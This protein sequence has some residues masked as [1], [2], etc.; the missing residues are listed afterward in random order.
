MCIGGDGTPHEVLNGIMDRPNGA[1]ILRR[2]HLCLVPAGT[3]NGLTT[4]IGISSP[5]DSFM[6]LVHGNSRQA[7]AM[8]IEQETNPQFQ[9]VYSLLQVSFG[10]MSDVDF[11]SE[12]IRWMGD[13]RFETL[14]RIT[15]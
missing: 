14:I 15:V 7:D 3:G 4:S 6:R 8:V 11:E 12:K 13:L 1:D 9:R 5:Q 10:M 2:I